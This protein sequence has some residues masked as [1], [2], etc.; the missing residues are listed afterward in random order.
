MEIILPEHYYSAQPSS[1]HQC[2]QWEVVI[3][4][5][6]LTFKSDAGV[7][8]KGR[9]DTGTKLLIEAV[10][11]DPKIR[12]LLDLGCGYGPIGLTLARL[13]PHAVIYMSDINER[14]VDLAR[15]NAVQNGIRNVVIQAGPGFSP[16]PGR[17]FDMIL[18]NPPVRAGKDV[19][20][21]L[22]EQ[23]RE[24]LL[25]G[26]WFAAVMLTR[27]GAKSFEAKLSEVFGNV[28]EWDKGSGYRVMAS[29]AYAPNSL[30]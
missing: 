2:L 26:G 28:C 20:Y 16:F 1:K 8:S 18:T 30:G 5:Q 15:E 11:L 7:F 25:D 12:S 17:R 14:A 10:P 24:A 19:I 6:H 9:L 21:P 27:Q 13:L 4:G 29:R 22:I 3:R 23:S